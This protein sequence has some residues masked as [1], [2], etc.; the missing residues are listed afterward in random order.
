MCIVD[1][2]GELVGTYRKRFLYQTDKAWAEEGDEEFRSFEMLGLKV[3]FGICMDINP[4]EFDYANDTFALASFCK[5]LNV[6]ILLFSTNWIMNDG[7]EDNPGHLHGYWTWRL[8]PLIGKRCLFVAANRTGVER[9]TTFAGESCI[10]SL[11]GPVVLAA[12]DARS[13]DVLI[14]SYPLLKRTTCEQL[15]TADIT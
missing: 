7:D 10:M 13:D 5:K 14:T 15:A 12:A 8:K 2:H 4:K 3:A 6:D 1:Q 9:G 11:S